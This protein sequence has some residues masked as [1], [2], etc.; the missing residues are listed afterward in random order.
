MPR[1]RILLNFAKQGTESGMTLRLLTYPM[2]ESSGATH[3]NQLGPPRGVLLILHIRATRGRCSDSLSQT[4][5]S[6]GNHGPTDGTP[7]YS[8]FD[9]FWGYGRIALRCE[10]YRVSI[11]VPIFHLA[12]LCSASQVASETSTFSP[13]Y[14]L[15]IGKLQASW[16]RMAFKNV[17]N[18]GPR[19]VK[20]Q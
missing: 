11:L 5:E 8:G 3:G 17:D 16:L 6:H 10:C 15:R 2:L 20:S 13:F 1:P 7:Q 18:L 12:C 4:K 9:G 19:F 14:T